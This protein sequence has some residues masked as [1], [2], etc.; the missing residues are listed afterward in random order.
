MYEYTNIVNGASPKKMWIGLQPLCC[1]AEGVTAV[2]CHFIRFVLFCKCHKIWTVTTKHKMDRGEKLSGPVQM[3]F[4][5]SKSQVL[6]P[7]WLRMDAIQKYCP[8]C[9]LGF[10]DGIT[11]PRQRRIFA[12]S[13]TRQ[14]E[15][16]WNSLRDYHYTSREMVEM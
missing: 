9:T 1:L 5:A 10:A 3:L 7:K 2:F 11:F 4:E 13:A 12:T 15:T 14:K 16:D 6:L 8:R